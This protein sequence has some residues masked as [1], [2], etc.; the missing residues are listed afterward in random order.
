MKAL[1]VHLAA[2]V[3]YALI[4]FFVL[5]E[6]KTDMQMRLN[7]IFFALIPNYIAFV[8]CIKQDYYNQK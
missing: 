4:I 6:Q 7:I 2:N 3:I 1:L 5:G 8:F